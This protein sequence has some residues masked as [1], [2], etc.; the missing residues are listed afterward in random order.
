MEN[1]KMM[2]RVA[3]ANNLSVCPRCQGE[4]LCHHEVAPWV[5]PV[6]QVPQGLSPAEV[7]VACDTCGGCGLVRA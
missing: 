6:A 4:G 3:A 1:K 7:L 5:A 2:T